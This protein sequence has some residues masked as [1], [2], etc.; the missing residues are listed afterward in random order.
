ARHCRR[1]GKVAPYAVA[2]FAR[3]KSLAVARQISGDVAQQP[4]R[5]DENHDPDG[6]ENTPDEVRVLHRI[7]ALVLSANAATTWRVP[8]T[9]HEAGGAQA[10]GSVNGTKHDD[11]RFYPETTRGE[12]SEAAMLLM[13]LPFVIYSASMQMFLDSFGRAAPRVRDVAVED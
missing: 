2:A 5:C 6:D 11:K 7:A 4:G 13:C 1:T 12:P 3:S 9:R 10:A 8:T